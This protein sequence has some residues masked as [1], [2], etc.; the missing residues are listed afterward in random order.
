ML[1]AGKRRMSAARLTG[2][3]EMEVI[4]HDFG[5]DA[6]QQA[7]QPTENIARKALNEVEEA[8]ATSNCST[9]ASAATTSPASSA[10]HHAHP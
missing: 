2:P 3:S 8:T 4:T 5:E 9:S 10:Q 7:A 1:I 6:T